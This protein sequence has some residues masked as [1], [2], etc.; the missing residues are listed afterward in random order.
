MSDGLEYVI[1]TLI[2][3]LISIPVS[4]LLI[5][6]ITRDYARADTRATMKTEYT[7]SILWYRIEN[8][9]DETQHAI[10]AAS[11]PRARRLEGHAAIR[12][13]N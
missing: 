4:I 9:D 1:G 5:L 11:S 3:M 2:G 8:L 13:D 6:I 7:P 10:D 12:S